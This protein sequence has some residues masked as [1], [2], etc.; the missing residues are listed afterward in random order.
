MKKLTSLILLF[1]SLNSFHLSAQKESGTPQFK[2]AIE[3]NNYIIAEQTKINGT[4]TLLSDAIQ[5]GT[6]DDMDK[7]L[8]AV[9]L[10]AKSSCAAIQKL[11]SYNKN[12]GFRNSAQK[13]FAFY[14]H[15]SKK[16]FRQ[17]I[18]I[19]KKGDRISEK[20]IKHMNKINES[21]T[22]KETLLYEAFTTAQETFAKENN[23]TIGN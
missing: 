16:E 2:T 8:D 11:D 6:N 15:I 5:S 18:K 3:Y 10:Q 21:I 22:K 13:L 12:E 20:D 17:M 7:A 1:V 9:N 19:L 23:F 14:S 4:M